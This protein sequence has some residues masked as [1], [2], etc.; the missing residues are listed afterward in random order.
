MAA[1]TSELTWLKSI[2]SALG[3]CH[4][5]PMSLSCDNT[6]AVHI[7]SNKVFHECTKHIEVDC[8]EI[9]ESLEFLLHSIFVF[10]NVFIS[11]PPFFIYFFLSPLLAL[12]LKGDDTRAS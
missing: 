10:H 11:F 4:S 6:A 8:H 9:S 7:A 3:V 5:K 2:L 1:A 12:Q